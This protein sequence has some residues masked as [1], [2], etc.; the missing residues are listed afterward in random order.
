MA[1]RHEVRDAL[2]VALR[3]AASLEM[4]ESGHV[5]LMAQV[6]QLRAQQPGGLGPETDYGRDPS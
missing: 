5:K 3:A 4:D 1:D 2:T 6:A